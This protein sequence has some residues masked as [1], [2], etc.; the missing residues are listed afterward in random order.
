MGQSALHLQCLLLCTCFCIK[1]SA[2]FMPWKSLSLS[3]WPGAPQSLRIMT[4]TYNSSPH[5][6]KNMSLLRQELEKNDPKLIPRS[7]SR[8]LIQD[9][10]QQA[11]IV[12]SELWQ[13]SVFWL[14][15]HHFDE[16]SKTKAQNTSHQVD[17]WAPVRVFCVH[18]TL[19]GTKIWFGVWSR[20]PL[21]LPCAQSS[22]QK[23]HTHALRCC[24]SHS[25]ALNHRWYLRSRVHHCGTGRWASS[26]AAGRR[27]PP[28]CR[29]GNRTNPGEKKRRK[30][31]AVSSTSKHVVI[32]GKRSVHFF[33]VLA[34]LG[35][36]EQQRYKWVPLYPNTDNLNSHLIR[37]SFSSLISAMLICPLGLKF[38]WRI[39]LGVSFSDKAGGTCIHHVE[40]QKEFTL[41]FGSGEDLVTVSSTLVDELSPSPSCKKKQRQYKTSKSLSDE[42]AYSTPRPYATLVP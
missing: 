9:T 14:N 5:W 27:S 30:F 42:Y 3:I 35:D 25:R 22:N 1:L 37:S 15:C 21:C 12:K 20:A 33:W 36:T 26:W 17:F 41:P 11:Q 28:T 18:S 13:P 32:L 16:M 24:V 10:T 6:R 8:V 19:M 2:N 4:H 7:G 29:T 40:R 38:S 34:L 39:L 31:M 23:A